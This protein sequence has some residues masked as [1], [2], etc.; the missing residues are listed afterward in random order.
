MNFIREKQE[1][2]QSTIDNSEW[3]FASDYDENLGGE[4]IVKQGA[5]QLVVENFEEQAVV[6]AAPNNPIAQER[7]RTG[8]GAN[9]TTIRRSQQVS[10]GEAAQQVNGR[11][12][13]SF[14]DPN[15]TI[16]LD[17]GRPVTHT[18]VINERELSEVIRKLAVRV[19]G[20]LGVGKGD[21][22]DRLAAIKLYVPAMENAMRSL[23]SQMMTKV[24]AARQN[25]AESTGFSLG[26]Q[27]LQDGDVGAAWREYYSS[28]WTSG[29]YNGDKGAATK[30]AFEALK[31]NATVG[32][33]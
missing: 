1:K 6:D 3:M 30:R 8:L 22:K 7:L 31:Y 19:T 13:E 4:E 33:L 29:K 21:R 25:N 26:A 17:N 23:E 15:T 12:F 28:A 10:L 5:T 27:L 2:E 16:T 14:F 20:E 11:L 24:T 18:S 9:E 32:Q